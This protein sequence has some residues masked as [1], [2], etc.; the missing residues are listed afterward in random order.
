MSEWIISIVG[1]IMLGVLLEIV[2]PEGKTA[3]Y[4]R[5]AFS[6]LVVFAIAAPLPGLFKKKWDVS[7]DPGAFTVD[8]AYVAG[9][10]EDYSNR[11][12]MALEK[13][14]S[15]KGIEATVRAEVESGK[16]ERVD[17]TVLAGDAGM[18][19]EAVASRLNIDLE[20]VT[21]HAI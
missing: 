12:S 16:I 9:A 8:E 13:F 1:V 7:V 17:I 10:Y 15:E 20:R 11:L 3:K 19:A 4:V 2:L 14:L 5:G 18:A 21:A 6:L